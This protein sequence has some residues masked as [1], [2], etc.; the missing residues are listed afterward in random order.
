MLF[1]HDFPGLP[2]EEH[3]CTVCV[4]GICMMPREATQ[5]LSLFVI[6][7][8]YLLVTI[9]FLK[10]RVTVTVDNFFYTVNASVTHYI[11]AKTVIIVTFQ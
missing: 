1:L 8:L 3:I 10:V 5:S 7:Y 6:Q 2:L 4:V 11:P 9:T